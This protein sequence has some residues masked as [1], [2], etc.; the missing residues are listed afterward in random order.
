MAGLVIK[1]GDGLDRPTR[2]AARGGPDV[3]PAVAG[4]GLLE[5]RKLRREERLLILPE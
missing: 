3:R 5:G 1:S 4:R 2:I